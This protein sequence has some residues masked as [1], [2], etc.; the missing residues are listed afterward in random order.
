MRKEVEHGVCESIP[1]GDVMQLVDDVETDR[2]I[3]ALPSGDLR[4]ETTYALIAEES[5]LTLAVGS[6]LESNWKMYWLG[7]E[8]RTVLAESG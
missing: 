4:I 5:E 2:E 7:L 8:K 6:W 3:N 1:M